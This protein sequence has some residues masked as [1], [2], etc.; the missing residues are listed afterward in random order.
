VRQSHPLAGLFPTLE[1]AAFDELVVDISAH[2]LREPVVLLDGMILDGRNRFRACITAHIEPRFVAYTGDD[3]LAFVVSANLHRRHLSES[4]RAMVAAKLAALRRGANQHS[5]EHPSI[6]GSSTLLNVGRASVERAKV[7]RRDGVPDLVDA[8][9]RGFVSVAAAADVATLPKGQQQEIV[10]RG[11]REIL[12][13]AKAI[14]VRMTEERHTARVARLAALATSVPMPDRLFPLIYADPPWRFDVFSPSGAWR[15]ADEHYPTMDLDDIKALKVPA[16][17]DCALF[18]WGTQPMLPQA[19][20]VMAAW[21][22]G[23]RSHLV[24]VKDHP[25]TGYW[26]RNR[27]ELLLIGARGDMPAPAP[28]A[29]PESVLF[30]PVGRHSEKPVAAYE[31]IERMYPTLPKLELFARATR[32][33]WTAWGNEVQAETSDDGIPEFLRRTAP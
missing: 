5:G 12:Q 32:P 6:E 14:R 17:E 24:W 28:S 26:A 7:I 18:L 9:E 27:H 31:I 4:Q 10:A 16:A 2:G 3:P 21:G 33:G 29:R 19:L 20:E 25:G 13:A 1:G 11:E 30:A 22:F 15:S 23:Y 8:V